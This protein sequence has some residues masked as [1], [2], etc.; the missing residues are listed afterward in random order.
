MDKN[1]WDIHG[2]SSIKK[3]EILRMLAMNE[4]KSVNTQSIKNL[5]RTILMIS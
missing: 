3:R 4:A 2:L 5:R 1:I